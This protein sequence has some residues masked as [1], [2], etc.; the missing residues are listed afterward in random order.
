MCVEY[1]IWTLKKTIKPPPKKKHG[2]Y[3]VFL[4]KPLIFGLKKNVVFST[5][6][7]L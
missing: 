5:S 3:V 1:E 7:C 2:F 6:F 4:N